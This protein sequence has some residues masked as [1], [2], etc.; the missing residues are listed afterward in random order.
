[1]RKISLLLA[2]ILL[3]A[4]CG[5]NSSGN[6]IAST[7]DRDGDNIAP[8]TTT[9]TTTSVAATTTTVPTT[10]VA[11]PISV[12]P[13]TTTA[14]SY[15]YDDYNI[16]F[17]ASEEEYFDPSY[18][19]LVVDSETVPLSLKALSIISSQVFVLNT[20]DVYPDFY[21]PVLSPD[22]TQ[23]AFISSEQVHVM[24]L[25]GSNSTQLTHFENTSSIFAE[26]S[27]SH[28]GDYLAFERFSSF[29]P[30]VNGEVVSSESGSLLF[31]VKLD[32]T[33]LTQI[34]EGTYSDSNFRQAF[35]WSPTKNELLYIAICMED[36]GN[37]G[38]C[39]KVVNHDGSPVKTINVLTSDW[40]SI[41][42]PDWS[43][44]GTRL[45][46]TNSKTLERSGSD[47]Y[48]KVFL[49]DLEGNYQELVEIDTDLSSF[50]ARWSDDE[51]RIAFFAHT[52][53]PGVDQPISLSLFVM[54][55]NGENLESSILSLDV[56]GRFFAER[57]IGLNSNTGER[58]PSLAW[59]PDGQRVTVMGAFDTGSDSNDIYIIDAN[60]IT[61]KEKRLTKGAFVQGVPVW[62]PTNE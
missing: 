37:Y 2:V 46:V 50:G 62:L 44:D 22:H 34:G 3:A 43:S 41:D 58:Q 33:Q 11:P 23:V 6:Q 57:S 13:T 42:L 24:D 8:T 53:F 32:G 61:A 49:M 60:N 39:Y 4:S 10:S 28:D 36:P 59:S 40:G 47:L 52:H 38:N 16:L 30:V 51:T 35:T 26:I 14:P 12:A 17:I 55:A 7:S 31:T 21:N 1:M 29:S 45:L 18:S 56:E 9:V 48:N 54:D 20:D 15:D 5:S 25:D 19:A 27:W